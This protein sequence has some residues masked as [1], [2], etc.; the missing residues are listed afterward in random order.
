MFKGRPSTCSLNKISI[1]LAITALQMKSSLEI[2]KN[3][4]DA[5]CLLYFL[6]LKLGFGTV[7]VN[8]SIKK[9]VNNNYTPL[10]FH[11]NISRVK[12]EEI[13][14]KNKVGTFLIRTSETFSGD[15]VLSVR[16]PLET[17]HIR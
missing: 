11:G 5:L 14:L 8:V 1:K 6:Y 2:K 10:I 16:Y 13:L 15:L 17:V 3:I 4:D 9:K 12:A 7:N